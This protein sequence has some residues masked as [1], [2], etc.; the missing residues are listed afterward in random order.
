MRRLQE[1]H[2][3]GVPRARIALSAF[4]APRDREQALAAGFQ[5]HVAKPVDPGAL[6]RV[7]DEMLSDHATAL[8]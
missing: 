4:A 8:Q 2:G 3:A 6:V 7:L 5:R 1:Q